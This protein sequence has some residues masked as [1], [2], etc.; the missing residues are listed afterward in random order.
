[1]TK[2]LS[3]PPKKYQQVKADMKEAFE[4]IIDKFGLSVNSDMLLTTLVKESGFDYFSKKAKDII[5]DGGFSLGYMQ[6]SPY[7]V[8]D[9]NKAYASNYTDNDRNDNYLNLVIGSL[10]LNVCF[11]SAI[12]LM[13]KDPIF[14]AYKKYNGGNDETET[15]KNDMASIYANDCI[16]IYNQF[17][18]L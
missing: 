11:L 13:A 6:I 18:E 5:G 16:K 14:L 1:M 10:F 2:N 15:S 7:A 17:K 12:K 9:V 8:K 4:T 3:S